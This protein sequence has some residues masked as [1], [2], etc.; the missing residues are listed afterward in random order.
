MELELAVVRLIDEGGGCRVGWESPVL[1]AVVA[2]RECGRDFGLCS[3]VFTLFG[4]FDLGRG[5]NHFFFLPL[6]GSL[7]PMFPITRKGSTIAIGRGRR[8]LGFPGP[9][10]L[11]HLAFVARFLDVF[12]LLHGQ[13]P[14]EEQSPGGNNAR[15]TRSTS[16]TER[17]IVVSRLTLSFISM[18][19]CRDL[20]DRGMGGG[21]LSHSGRQCKRQPTVNC[22]P[23]PEVS[24]CE[25]ADSRR[26]PHPRR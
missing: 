21:D 25:I 5:T 23:P 7:V 8:R 22:G 3:L 17:P 10:Q 26:S 11:M 6:L 4:L 13:S 18:P 16:K 24:R 15:I 12:R 1:I 19:P 9:F 20:E 14:R 2:R